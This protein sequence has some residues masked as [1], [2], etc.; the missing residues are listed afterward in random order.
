MEKNEL[1]EIMAEVLIELRG[2]RDTGKQTNRHLESM[3]A[4]LE[5]MDARL[6]SMDARLESMDARL[7]SVDVRLESVDAHITRVEER[8]AALENSHVE[9]LAS[10]IRIEK[11]LGKVS[12]IAGEAWRSTVA[13]ANQA[14]LFKVHEARIIKLEQAVYK[15]GA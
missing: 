8:F 6:E 4:R 2:I 3:D 11:E 12:A 1:E 9:T 7:E 13:L 5:S 15:K 10:M 14:E